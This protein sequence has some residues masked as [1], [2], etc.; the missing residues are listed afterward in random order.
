MPSLLGPA[1]RIET[2]RLVLRCWEPSDVPALAA[3][4]ERDL[5]A[6]R[7]TE[8]WVAHEPKSRDDRLR[9]VRQWRAEFDLDTRWRYAVLDAADGRLAGAATLSRHIAGTALNS[10]GWRAPGHA[11]AEAAAALARVAFELLDAPKVQ[12]LFAA[13]DECAAAAH[14]ALGFTHDGVERRLAGG[15]RRDVALWSLLPGEWPA[16]PAAAAAA[17][18]RAFDVLGNRLF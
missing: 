13:G 2:P 17:A 9:E 15:M 3:L 14:R 16:S 10:H 11:G 8:R 1:Y 5:E 4:V 12:A 18:A 6:L 7:A